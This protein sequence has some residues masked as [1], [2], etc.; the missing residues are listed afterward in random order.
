MRTAT[1]MAALILVP[2]A[3]VCQTVPI[4]QWQSGVEGW[5]C[6]WSDRAQGRP[7]LVKI[8]S[9]QSP[10]AG[11]GALLTFAAADGTRSWA[12]CLRKVNGAA[13]AKAQT[14]AL[15]LRLRL[16]SSR[17]RVLRV[18]F[19]SQQANKVFKRDVLLLPN[20]WQEI[21]IP[22]AE[23]QPK[24][25]GRLRFVPAEIDTLS[26]VQEGGWPEWSVLLGPI[27]AVRVTQ[28]QPEV[29]GREFR[30]LKLPAGDFD[31]EREA[32][33]ARF[34]P[35]SKGPAQVGEVPFSL[36][37]RP[38]PQAGASQRKLAALGRG[39]VQALH[40]LHFAAG[41][42]APGTVIAS[43]VVRY[44]DGGTVALPVT[45]GENVGS[46]LWSEKSNAPVL[47]HGSRYARE[48]AV[49]AYLMTWVN[50]ERYRPIKAISV[51]ALEP[52][53]LLVTAAI[54]AQGEDLGEVGEALEPALRAE[55]APGPHY[56]RER[57]EWWA[58]G[59][60]IT[61]VVHV[62]DTSL[63]QGRAT[64]ELGREVPRPGADVALGESAGPMR[65]K[66]KWRAA[67]T[68][69]VPL[70]AKRRKSSFDLTMTV[71]AGTKPGECQV[72]VKIEAGT[73]KHLLRP[74]RRVLLDDRL[75]VVSFVDVGG[76]LDEESLGAEFRPGKRTTFDGARVRPL[77]A[78]WPKKFP[79]YGS[80][81]PGRPGHL[82][83]FKV[84]VQP[85]ERNLLSVALGRAGF[86]TIRVNGKL[87]T[88]YLGPGWV[89]ATVV[90]DRPAT[91]QVTVC[92]ADTGT[93]VVDWIAVHTGPGVEIPRRI[94]AWNEPIRDSFV[95]VSADG[96]Y[97]V[98]DDGTP[99]FPVGIGEGCGFPPQYQLYSYEKDNFEEY[100]RKISPFINCTLRH[101]W[102]AVIT[103]AQGKIDQQQIRVIDDKMARLKKYGIYGIWDT[104]D[105][106]RKDW[107]P[108][109]SPQSDDLSW[110]LWWT[111]YLAE[112][113][114][115][116]R[117]ILSWGVCN[118][119]AGMGGTPEQQHQWHRAIAE[120]L[121]ATDANHLVG[122]DTWLNI[123][124][125]VE[126][127]QKFATEPALDWIALHPYKPLEY[128][129]VAYK[130]A[131]SWPGKPAMLNEFD[132]PRDGWDPLRDAPYHAGYHADNDT[133]LA[134]FMHALLDLQACT[135]PWYMSFTP[136][137]LDC[138][139]LVQRVTEQIDWSTLR[140]DP[141]F[142]IECPTYRDINRPE[143]QELIV[144]AS[145]DLG[146]PADLSFG[147][148][149]TP[150]PL[151]VIRKPADLK[152]A[153]KLRTVTANCWSRYLRGDNGRT[154]LAWVRP[155]RGTRAQA[156][157]VLPPGAYLAQWI[158]LRTG[159]VVGTRRVIGGRKLKLSA[160]E[161]E[162]LLLYVRPA[163]TREVSLRGVVLAG[164]GREPCSAV[165]VG[166]NAVPLGMVAG[167]ET[168]VLAY[169]E[170]KRLAREVFRACGVQ[171]PV[172]TPQEF[173][174]QLCRKRNVILAGGPEINDITAEY[175]QSGGKLLHLGEAAPSP[176]GGKRKV[177][178]VPGT[179]EAELAAAV[180]DL[181]RELV[182]R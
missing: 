48:R 46:F 95:R 82:A 81:G 97:L 101:L 10:D 140:P 153:D 107:P 91:E 57:G 148:A 128:A 100:C 62:G 136:E 83:D 68:Q 116:E 173:D 67:L 146:L 122:A 96:R 69:R 105:H 85:G 27:A 124:R 89:I 51:W 7:P 47:Q 121:K 72:R 181:T 31:V 178:Y 144:R 52:E 28:Q 17:P 182:V 152:R 39:Q 120:R 32:A 14:N 158:S 111:D 8:E 54:T 58:I 176:W 43:Y 64:V 13:L 108:S 71:P 170:L 80:E 1:L 12:S 45:F 29:T 177:I 22:Y 93:P 118:E 40:F 164:R 55:I 142:V 131:A 155:K 20:G 75:T 76:P 73:E 132:M 38:L 61:V 49:K 130:F 151:L 90:I 86:G 169:M 119:P 88:V 166:P 24:H 37:D 53:A 162:E 113:Y 135:Q 174:E 77:V 33:K 157:L 79:A 98:Y 127:V 143:V 18:L 163:P 60:V 156:K 44:A 171:P 25:G 30:A 26:L 160:P 92:V 11:L 23:F 41:E 117:H 99:I 84:G 36:T 138:L 106:I 87:G 179:S 103:P 154:C 180:R 34:V 19:Y 168:P 139:G 65:R 78:P 175:L 5:N 74:R 147:R 129:L 59:D 35:W 145:R 2:V 125:E 70:G 21:T 102:P 159:E 161:A 50:P 150:P 9:A 165:L 3:A 110:Q 149:A 6:N 126:S 172:W 167:Y 115:D 137:T 15:K 141:D 66:T 56:D 133:Y 123:P 134:R 109:F 4:E 114:R 42:P 94:W 112:R 104:T 16:Q 63:P